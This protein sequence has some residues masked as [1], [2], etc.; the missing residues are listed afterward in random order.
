MHLMGESLENR[1]G[2]RLKSILEHLANHPLRAL[3][4]GAGVTAAVQS[5]SATTVMVVGFVNSGIMRLRQ[6]IYVIMGANIGTTVTGWLLS[7]TGIRSDNVFIALLKPSSFSPILAAIGIIV[8]LTMKRNRGTAG[9]LLGFAI[10]MYGMDHM[11]GAVRGLSDSALFSRLLMA[12]TNPLIGIAVGTLVTAILQ[13]SSAS[14]GVLQAVA[15]AG[16]LSFGAAVPIIMGQNI[17]TC[18]TAV[19]AVIGANR[20]AKRV[21]L[22]H[23]YFN[24][25]GTLLFLTGYYSLS[26]LMHFHWSDEPIHALGIAIVHTAFNLFSTAVLFPFARQL[27]RL[28]IRTIPDGKDQQSFEVLDERLLATPSFAIQQARRLTEEMAA[29]SR[30][31]FI[32]ALALLNTFDGREAERILAEEDLV[33]QY[34]DKLGAYLVRISMANLDHVS[35]R[36]VAMLL[37]IIGDFERISD[38][39]ANM[40]EVAQEISDKQ[41]LFSDSAT[42]ELDVIRSAVSEVLEI[43]VEAFVRHDRQLA[44][45]VEALEEVVNDLRSTIKA[46][47]IE[48]LQ[49]GGCTI[50]MGFVLSDLL[51]NLERC[52]DHCSNIAASIV[53]MQTEGVSE[54][55]EYLRSLR[56]GGSA[57]QGFRDAHEEYQRKYV[58]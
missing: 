42:H 39:A 54:P 27:E 51:T 43:T 32:S 55:H 4:L 1:T 3:L 2:T 7:L 56:E 48:R 19:L 50:E 44:E 31:G 6:A 20:D 38:H 37:H 28:A 16:G 53:E 34:E 36:E 24:I 21:A 15:N 11:S 35:S 18:I 33:D 9:I 8:M 26:Q 52:S 25:I 57:G 41:L 58:I 22:I 5:S 17:G 30:D 45:R 12:C 46:N 14:I 47:H 49:L 40:V 10:L 23:L 13:S 29:K